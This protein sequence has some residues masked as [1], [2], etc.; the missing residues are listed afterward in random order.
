MS[1][2]TTW[3]TAIADAIRGKD[4]TEDPIDHVS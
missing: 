2:L 3:L 4:G 1:A